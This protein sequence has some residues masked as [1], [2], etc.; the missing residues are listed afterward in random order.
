MRNTILSLVLTASTILAFSACNKEQLPDKPAGIPLTISATVGT[1]TKT[2]YE[3]DQESRPRR[4]EA[5]CS[6]PSPR[7]TPPSR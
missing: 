7:E 3:Y 1:Q 6:A 5:S 2:L 4:R